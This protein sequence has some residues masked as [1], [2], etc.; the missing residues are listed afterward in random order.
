VDTGEGGQGQSVLGHN[1]DTYSSLK[2]LLVA[3]NDA[4]AGSVLKLHTG[5]HRDTGEYTIE[6]SGI[7]IEAKHP[8]KA[9]IKPHGSGLMIVIKGNNNIIKGLQFVNGYGMNDRGGLIEVRGNNNTLTNLNFYKVYVNHYINIVAGSQYNVVSYSNFEAKPQNKAR[10]GAIVVIN[11]DPDVIGYHRVHH[12]SFQNMDGNGEDYGN[13]PLR[14]GSDGLE[15]PY[16]SRVRGPRAAL[17][18]PP[19]LSSTT[20]S[21]ARTYPTPHSGRRG[22]QRLQQHVFGRQRND[23]HQ[24]A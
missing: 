2:K 15:Q 16:I 5:T 9:I 8:G 7:T 4:A 20:P 24:I 17:V 1:Y 18:P 21:H 22:A 11:T 23:F 13:E 6:A 19:L 10:A 14:I 12:C 3:A